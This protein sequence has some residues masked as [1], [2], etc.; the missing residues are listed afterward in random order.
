[1]SLAV[2]TA[3]IRPAAGIT[4]LQRRDDDPTPRTLPP[5]ASRQQATVHAA[6]RHGMSVRQLGASA[7]NT[8]YFALP[9]G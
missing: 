8:A 4:V 3:P 2:K 1:M 9:Q 7:P 5:A 6:S